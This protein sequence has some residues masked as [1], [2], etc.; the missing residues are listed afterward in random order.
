MRFKG[1]LAVNLAASIRTRQCFSFPRR[2]A[3]FWAHLRRKIW[4]AKFS[5]AGYANLAPL[6]IVLPRFLAIITHGREAYPPTSTLRWDRKYFL[7]STGSRS[8]W[9]SSEEIV[10]GIR[11]QP[12]LPCTC[13]D[14]QQRE[15]SIWVSVIFLSQPSK[16]LLAGV[17]LAGDPRVSRF[18]TWQRSFPSKFPVQSSRIE[19]NPCQNLLPNL[20]IL[21]LRHIHI[22]F[23]VTSNWSPLYDLIFSL[24]VHIM[25]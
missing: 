1:W 11:I 18:R 8:H 24:C 21:H 16:A 13:N 23:L 17:P 25:V 7:W 5:S 22:I 6:G 4:P 12:E 10:G 20:S 15:W 14:K 3:T 9:N 19:L 2:L